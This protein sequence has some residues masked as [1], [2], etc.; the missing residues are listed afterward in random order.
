MTCNFMLHCGMELPVQAKYKASCQQSYFQMNSCKTKSI[1]VLIWL[2]SLVLS[3]TKQS[4][5]TPLREPSQ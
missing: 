3:L 4:E 5:R 2:G 1:F